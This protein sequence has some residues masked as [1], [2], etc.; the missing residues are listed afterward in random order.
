MTGQRDGKKTLY[1]VY[2]MLLLRLQDTS[3]RSQ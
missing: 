1:I 3:S 2:V